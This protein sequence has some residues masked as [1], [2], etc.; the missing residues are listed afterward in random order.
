MAKAG[1][2]GKLDTV[3]GPDT[4]VKGDFRVAGSLRLDGS[5]EGRM[6][7]SDTLLTGPRSL[8]KGDVHCR[9]AVIA[10]RIEGGIFAAETVE[11]QSGAQV[12]GNITCRG[13]V[14]QRDCFFEGTCSMSEARRTAETG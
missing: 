14:I 1:S 9:D 12:F 11:L 8:L 6:D 4:S 5:V 10:G 13:L 3:V 7:V 2:E